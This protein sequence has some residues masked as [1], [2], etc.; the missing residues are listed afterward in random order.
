[1]EPN[2]RRSSWD[3]LKVPTIITEYARMDSRVVDT[4]PIAK[5]TRTRAF[6]KI[7]SPSNAQKYRSVGDC[8]TVRNYMHSRRENRQ[9]W[10]KLT[11]RAPRFKEFPIS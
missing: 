5:T 8:I 2:P 4:V 1:M 3:G 10:T 11:P 7:G 9:V 6:R